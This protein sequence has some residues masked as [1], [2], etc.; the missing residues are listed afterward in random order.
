[1]IV[2]ERKQF[3]LVIAHA[4]TIHKSQGSTLEYMIGDL[5]QTTKT[6][7]RKVPVKEGQFYTLLSRAKNRDN[8]KLLNLMRIK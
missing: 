2:A 4:I 6:G 1:M 5:N 8:I 3:P 7:D